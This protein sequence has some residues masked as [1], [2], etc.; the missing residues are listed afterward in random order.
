MLYC[1]ITYYYFIAPIYLSFAYAFATAT[2]AQLD[3]LDF[4]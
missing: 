4:S 3:D 2:V 1:F